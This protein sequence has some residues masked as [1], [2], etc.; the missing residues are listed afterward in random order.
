MNAILE[1]FSYCKDEPFCGACKK[2]CGGYLANLNSMDDAALEK[3]KNE[4]KGIKH[5]YDVMRRSNAIGNC[6]LYDKI[7]S[8]IKARGWNKRR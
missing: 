6:P 5:S 3:A 2:I 7:D 4:I 1:V 8:I